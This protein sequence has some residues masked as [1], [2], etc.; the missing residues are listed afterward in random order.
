LQGIFQT[1]S[2]SS[3][4]SRRWVLLAD[5]CAIVAAAVISE[6][7]FMKGRVDRAT[8]LLSAGVYLIVTGVIIYFLTHRSRA[9]P[10]ADDSAKA[11][12]TQSIL[13]KRG[14]AYLAYVPRLLLGGALVGYTFWLKR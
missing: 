8:L 3:A 10:L 11:A 2:Q 6:G 14:P 13:G 1:M 5:L 7:G 4:T 12:P 9:I